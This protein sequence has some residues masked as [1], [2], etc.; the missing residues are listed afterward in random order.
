MQ[1]PRTIKLVVLLLAALALPMA[2]CG[3]KGN[4]KPPSQVE[5]EAKEKKSE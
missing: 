5:A 2:A 4:P 3:K 1:M